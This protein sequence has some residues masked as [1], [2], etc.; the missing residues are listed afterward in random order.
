MDNTSVR[1][2]HRA[3]EVSHSHTLLMVLLFL[4]PIVSP[5]ASVSGEARIESQDFEIL[6]RLSEVLEE[7]QEV[8]DSNSV[9]QMAGPTI[10]GISNSVTP[11]GSADPLADVDGAIE[12]AT[13][14]VTRPPDPVHPGPYQLLVDPG[15]RPPGQVDNVWQTLLNITDYVIWTQYT[16]LDGDVIESFEVVTFSSNLLSLLDVN[17]DPLLHEVDIDNDGDEDIEVGLKI[18][19]EFLGGWGVED[20]VLWIE[21]GISYSVKVLDSSQNDPDWDDMDKLQVSLIKAF[22]YSGPDSILALG[23]GETYIWVVDSRFTTQP[24]DFTLRVGIERFY[25]DVTG[26]G[27]VLSSA[28]YSMVSRPSS[29]STNP[30]SGRTLSVLMTI[31]TCSGSMTASLLGCSESSM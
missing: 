30:F 15:S 23:E 27:S 1:L 6:D 11:T 3:P 21:P 5:I 28:Q 17:S 4:L 7:R 12:G 19:W 18:A 2:V 8:L 24:N 10:E 13:M 16:N 14:A 22:A 29:P 9:G 25:F 26:A 20:G 31:S